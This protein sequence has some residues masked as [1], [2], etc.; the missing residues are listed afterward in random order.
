MSSAARIAMAAAAVAVVSTRASAVNL[1]NAGLASCRVRPKQQGSNRTSTCKEKLKLSV[2]YSTLSLVLGGFSAGINAHMGSSITIAATAL[3]ALRTVRGYGNGGGRHAAMTISPLAGVAAHTDHIALR[4]SSGSDAR[5]RGA[6][7]STAVG[8]FETW[9]FEFDTADLPT[10]N[11]LGGAYM[12]AAS[13]VRFSAPRKQLV[14]VVTRR[15]FCSGCRMVAECGRGTRAIEQFSTAAFVVIHALVVYD[16]AAVLG[17][18]W[19]GFSTLLFRIGA[20][21]RAELA[22]GY[23][24]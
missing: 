3:A 8:V 2:H 6:L 17:P 18:G 19:T 16:G 12:R 10:A 24:Q 9:G 5:I 4:G 23:S 15:T 11:G 20:A 21:I 14:C 22:R 1:R 7:S 13:C